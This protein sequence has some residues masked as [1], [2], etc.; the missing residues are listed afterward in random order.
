MNISTP[1]QQKER[2]PSPV[3]KPRDDMQIENKDA[4]A[5]DKAITYHTDANNRCRWSSNIIQQARLLSKTEN[6]SPIE[7]AKCLD[8]LTIAHRRNTTTRDIEPNIINEL[9][10]SERPPE[11][12]FHIIQAFVDVCKT[13]H[14]GASPFEVMELLSKRNQL[15]KYDTV[16]DIA[17][18]MKE[19]RKNGEL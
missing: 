19:L 11:Y 7:W 18:I 16:L 9:R 4:R 10:E 5:L 14:S 12:K 17:D 8:E 1:S 2:N 3:I 13:T 15:A 6:H